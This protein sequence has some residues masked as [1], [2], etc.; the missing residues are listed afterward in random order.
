M[1]NPNLVQDGAATRFGQPGGPDPRGDGSR[2]APWSIRQNLR[3]LMNYPLNGSGLP[4]TED[5][6]RWLAGPN[7]QQAT[8][9]MLMAVR[10]YQQAMQSWQAMN[11][12]I[13]DVDGKQADKQITSRIPFS[14][15]VRQ[16]MEELS[17]PH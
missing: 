16:S 8:L 3:R 10:R 14:E 7:G 13:D 12:L 5:L 1:N 11:A 9:A 17:D 15:I 6:L 4:S 2:S